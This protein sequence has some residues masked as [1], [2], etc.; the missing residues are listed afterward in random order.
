M[1][2]TIAGL[3]T[4]ALRDLINSSAPIPAELREQVYAHPD[5]A[6][7]SQEAIESYAQGSAADE[8]LEGLYEVVSLDSLK[9]DN[10]AFK[11]WD[12]YGDTNDYEYQQSLYEAN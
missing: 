10:L 2:A 3:T 5:F 11:V 12:K 8:S 1:T 9:E 7:L 6:R 4:E